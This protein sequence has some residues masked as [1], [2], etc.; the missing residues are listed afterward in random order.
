VRVLHR[1]RVLVCGRERN[2]WRG[3]VWRRL[4][5]AGC[6]RLRRNA[7]SRAAI[8]LLLS[9]PD[10]TSD[11]CGS[12]G[13][14]TIAPARRRQ[15]VCARLGAHDAR[16]VARGTLRPEILVLGAGLAGLSASLAFARNGHRVLLLERDGP[17]EHGDADELF[18]CWDRRGIAHF[19]QPHNFLALAHQVLPEEAPDVIDAVIG[20]GAFENRQ[21]ELI[22]GGSQ[23]GDEALVSICARRPVF[24][25]AFRRAVDAEPNI[26]VEA[27]TRVV[28][29]VAA[30]APRECAVRVG[31]ARTEKGQEVRADLVV[32]AL[33]RTSPLLAWLDALAARSPL[34]RRTECGLL[35]YS[36]HFRFRPG[37]EMPAVS[38]HPSGPRGDIGYMAFAV[39]VE[40]NRTFALVLM[41]PPWDRELRTLKSVQAYMA[42][43]L[44]MPALL[45]WVHP[46]QSDPITPVLPMGNLQNLHRS[47][48]VDGEPVAVGIQP[49][50]DALCQ[51]NPTFAYGASLS[52]YHG[53]TLARTAS[54]YDDARAI[55]LA[56]DESVGA[57]IAARFD[58]VSA[59][60]RDR[61]RLW[62]REPID[63]REPGDSMALFLRMTAYPAAGKDPDLFRAVARRINL[64]DP[65]DALE[66][67]EALIARAQQ[68]AGDSGPSPPVGPARSEL[69]EVIAPA[70]S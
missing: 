40:D 51:T 69:L 67:D 36:R 16:R 32:D 38:T 8:L 33:G 15:L 2:R 52:I 23:P 65:P 12:C 49:I 31:G 27:N 37:V 59:E 25:S 22:P 64:L 42:A 5:V 54:R 19:R 48:V 17:V 4:P 10:P 46:D 3:Q 24:E 29:L 63:V 62:Q 60:D 14:R 53:F 6:H 11:K 30:R 68:I 47:L 20:L 58:A 13:H 26:E 56:F 28:G 35:F 9:S 45:P 41:I 18:E 55:A 39:F 34:K 44:A 21:Y 43:A 50:G 7:G 70:S 1:Y 57:D 66:S 61:L